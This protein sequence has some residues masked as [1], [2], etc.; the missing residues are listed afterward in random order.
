M[1]PPAGGANVALQ[2]ILNHP[3]SLATGPAAEVLRLRTWLEE[4][5]AKHSNRTVERILDAL[6]VARGALYVDCYLR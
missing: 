3:P 2:G 5:L 6:R 4:T 1:S